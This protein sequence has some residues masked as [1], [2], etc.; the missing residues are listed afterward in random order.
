MTRLAP[1]P[2]VKRPADC[3]D[4]ITPEDVIRIALA[5]FYGACRSAEHPED[6][7]PWLDD[8]G[9]AYSSRPFLAEEMAEQF[10]L[11][12]YDIAHQ[13]GVGNYLQF[14][15]EIQATERAISQKRPVDTRL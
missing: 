3:W 13:K 8:K 10:R 1:L 4:W 15:R 11:R 9:Q 5:S 6:G 12:T 2:A 14:V 7:S